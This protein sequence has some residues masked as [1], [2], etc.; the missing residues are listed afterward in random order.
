VDHIIDGKVPFWMAV[1]RMG[2]F[3][4]EAPFK[5][6]AYMLAQSIFV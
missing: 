1:L 3:S 6:N 4:V 5:R 2:S